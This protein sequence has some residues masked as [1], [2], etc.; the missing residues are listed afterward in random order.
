MQ[1]L[2]CVNNLC[3]RCCKVKSA[4]DITDCHGKD[5][6]MRHLFLSFS[7]ERAALGALKIMILAYYYRTSNF[8]G[9]RVN[10]TDC[11]F[12]Y[13]NQYLQNFIP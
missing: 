1:G 13:F 10:F 6:L 11:V 8:Y 3:K 5:E 9:G 7:L 2:R 4:Q 12:L